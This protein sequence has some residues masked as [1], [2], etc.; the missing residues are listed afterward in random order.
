L[1]GSNISFVAAR[2]AHHRLHLQ[3][4]SGDQNDAILSASVV[5]GFFLSSQTAAP[6][7]QSGQQSQ[8]VAPGGGGAAG[9]LVS[10]GAILDTSSAL[11]LL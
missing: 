5:A 4:H 11:F 1:S 8:L 7:A 10:I 3:A 6:A 2:S 9:R